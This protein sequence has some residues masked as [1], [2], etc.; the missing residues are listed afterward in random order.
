MIWTMAELCI[1]IFKIKNIVYTNI[2]EI[3]KES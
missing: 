3:M 1:I 2:F